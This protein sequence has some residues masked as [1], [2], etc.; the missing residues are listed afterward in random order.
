MEK[1]QQNTSLLFDKFKSNQ[2]NSF[3]IETEHLQTQIG[4]LQQ[5]LKEKQ[6][7]VLDLE[8][9]NARLMR[10]SEK[11]RKAE[12]ASVETLSKEIEMLNAQNS[13][14]RVQLISSG[15]TSL[16]ADTTG[17]DLSQVDILFEKMI[18]ERG[19]GRMFEMV[20]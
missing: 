15:N 19:M 14:L 6:F 1:M 13:A 4:E 17:S 2:K 7:N 9:E 18:G 20:R 5:Q 3:A 8:T 11:A 12:K 10:E 16:V